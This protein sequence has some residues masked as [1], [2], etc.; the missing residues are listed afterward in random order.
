MARAPA[1]V[2][3]AGGDDETTS[4]VG[5]FVDAGDGSG[6]IPVVEAIRGLVDRAVGVVDSDGKVG[7]VPLSRA[8]GGTED[9]KLLVSA[10]GL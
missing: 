9:I 8:A 10:N 2:D 4:E 7:V 1:G 3:G 6:V 5:P